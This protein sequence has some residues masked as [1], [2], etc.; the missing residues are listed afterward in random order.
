MSL[1]LNTLKTFAIETRRKL[2]RLVADKISFVLA[3]ES[4]A[5]RSSPE[6]VRQL[7]KAISAHGRDHVIEETAY[8]W[9]NRFCALRFMDANHYTA[10]GVVSPA[11]GASRPEILAEAVSG[12]FDLALDERKKQR[13]LALLAGEIPSNDRFNDA[14]RILFI[15]SCNAWSD[16]MPFMFERIDD[17]TELLM[18][19]DLLSANSILADL[20]KAI[21]PEDCADVEI[22]GWLYQF[23]V[24]EKKDQIFAGLKKNK[25]ISKEEIPAATELFTPHW[26]VQ[27]LAEN[28]LG[29][30][31]MENHPD[32]SLRE[33]MQYF[34]PT[35]QIRAGT[36]SFSLP[37][38][39]RIPWP[40]R[41]ARL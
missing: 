28:S 13:V 21:T 6:S 16:I 4:S 37:A 12:N 35:S 30:L 19:D 36:A 8:Q 10:V 27:Y 40:D 29:R 25:K 32:S 20:R 31:W 41:P 39:R 15:A 38:D 17:Y 24:S 5:R 7:E 3:A 1:N 23:Y 34:I 11:D 14:Y 9:F 18:P 33:K 26:I 22:I 2:M